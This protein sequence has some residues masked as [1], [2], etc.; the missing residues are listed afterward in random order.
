APLN[1]RT[2]TS[3]PPGRRQSKI[4]DMIDNAVDRMVTV[5]FLKK[6][7]RF[8]VEDQTSIMYPMSPNLL[9]GNK[10]EEE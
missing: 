1:L 6:D 4:L 10:E 9:E 8:N 5:G 2:P 7:W 3:S